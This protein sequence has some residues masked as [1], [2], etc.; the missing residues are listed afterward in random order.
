MIFSW[1]APL[2]WSDAEEPRDLGL[3]TQPD[4]TPYVAVSALTLFIP[5]FGRK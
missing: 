3:G 4:S 5:N 1:I 2:Y